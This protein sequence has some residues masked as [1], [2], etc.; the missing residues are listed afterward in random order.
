MSDV[1]IVQVALL[2]TVA[3]LLMRPWWLVTH[4]RCGLCRSHTPRRRLRCRFCGAH[5]ALSA[6]TVAVASGAGWDLDHP[7]ETL[8][9]RKQ[10]P[11]GDDLGDLGPVDAPTIEA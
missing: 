5:V 1:M 10:V 9:R 11:V 4:R 3:T 6:P 8:G 7:S 2:L